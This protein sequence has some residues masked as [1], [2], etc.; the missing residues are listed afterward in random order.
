MSVLLPAPFAPSRAWISPPRRVKSTL[1][2]A[3]TPGKVLV[4]RRTESNGV[5]SVEQVEGQIMGEREC[6]MTN[7]QGPKNVQGQSTKT[8][9]SSVAI[10]CLVIWISSFGFLSGFVIR[11]S[12]FLR[13][14]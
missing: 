11:H 7:D 4:T 6:Q 14:L 9:A 10:R 8:T 3:R 1:S 5:S 13:L 12:D 2:S